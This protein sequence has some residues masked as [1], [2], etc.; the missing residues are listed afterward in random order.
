LKRFFQVVALGLAASALLASA[1]AAAPITINGVLGAASAGKTT[2]N[3]LDRAN[4][5]LTTTAACGTEGTFQDFASAQHFV[6]DAYVFTNANGSTACVTV[7]ADNTDEE[8]SSAGAL[9]ATAFQPTYNPNSIAT[10]WWAAHNGGMTTAG[11]PKA[12]SFN[13]PA[14]GTFVVV[15][16]ARN[17]NEGGGPLC[18]LP[19]TYTLTIDSNLG[20]P[21]AITMLAKSSARRT[22]HGAV[23]RWRTATEANQLGFNVF[24]Q[25]SGKRVKVSRSLLPSVFGGSVNGHAYS[26]VDRTAPRAGKLAYWIQSVSLNGTRSWSGPIAAS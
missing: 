6:Y 4:T 1:A 17:G 7:T 24:R 13:I 20:P 9:M 12:F 2:G 11:G 15:V 26:F 22:P 3:Q 5:S 14:N 10:T 25:V 21:T 23:V 19:C 16:N 18:T 8:T